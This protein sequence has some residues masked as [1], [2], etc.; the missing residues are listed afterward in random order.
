MFEILIGIV[1]II[2]GIYTL[3]AG[4]RNKP[5][6]WLIFKV[7]YLIEQKIIGPHFN[8]VFNYLLGLV[9]V[10]FGVLVIFYF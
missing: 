7:D 5:L 3:Y 9:E 2:H 6:T 10:I 8:K 4:Y 1:L